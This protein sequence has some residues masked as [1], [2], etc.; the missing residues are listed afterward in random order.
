[1]KSRTHLLHLGMVLALSACGGGD[2]PPSAPP[3]LEVPAE[4]STSST[5]LVS[6][7]TTLNVTDAEDREP[8]SIAGF[9]PQQPDDTEPQALN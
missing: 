6:Y 5:G 8:V 9:N 4:A 1:M 7:M 3:S 2:A